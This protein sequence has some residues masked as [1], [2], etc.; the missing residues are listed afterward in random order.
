LSQRLGGDEPRCLPSLSLRLGDVSSGVDLGGFVVG[1]ISRKY[2]V[3]P[4][5]FRFWGEVLVLNVL[6]WLFRFGD[7]WFEKLMLG[8]EWSGLGCDGDY[9]CGGG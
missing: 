2:V 3:L 7:M 8:W 4:T 5:G 1:W 6:Y 9:E